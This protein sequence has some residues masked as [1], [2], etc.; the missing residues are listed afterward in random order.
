MSS[1]TS[2]APPAEPA[3]EPREHLAAAAFASTM[4][5]AGQGVRDPG[6]GPVVRGGHGGQHGRSLTYGNTLIRA[7][8]LGR[9]LA[10]TWGPAQHVGL[11]VPP[12]VPAAVA[13]LAVTLWGKVPVNLNYSASQSLVDASVEQ[14]GITHV[15]TS[16]KVLDKFKI[17]PRGQLIL[18]EDIPSQVRLADKVWAAAV[19]RLVPTRVMGAFVPGLRGDN[20]DATATVIFTSGSTG[21]PKGVVLSHRNVLSNVYQVEEQVQLQARRGLAG[22]LAVFPLV[23]LH[24]H[25]L[26]GPLPEQEGRL[27]LQSARCP[28]IGKLCEKHKVTLSTATPSFMRL[29]LKRLR[30]AAVQDDHPPDRGCREAQARAGPGDP[31]DAG[32]RAAGGIRLH[33]ALAGRRGE[34]AARR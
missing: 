30:S 25:H 28:D 17:T 10:R 31:G 7:L 2:E 19:A 29:Y 6:A 9:V 8:V 20:L 24:D 11:L 15:L 18:L 1:G 16:A 12:T 27:S 34:R 21:D 26:D 32:H 13:N 23:R 14:C 22:R 33:R 3:L 5:V 4:A